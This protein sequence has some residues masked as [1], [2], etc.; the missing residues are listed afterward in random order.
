MYPREVPPGEVRRFNVCLVV[1]VYLDLTDMAKVRDRFIETEAVLEVTEEELKEKEAELEEK[2]AELE[3]KE[4]ALQEKEGELEEKN[5]TIRELEEQLAEKESKLE[6]KE[7]ALEEKEAALG[8]KDRVI[9]ELEEQ[10]RQLSLQR[11]STPKEK[12]PVGKSWRMQTR[13]ETLTPKIVDPGPTPRNP[14]I[15]RFIDDTTQQHVLQC[16]ILDLRIFFGN[17]TLMNDISYLKIFALIASI[18]YR[19]ALRQAKVSKALRYECR[20][21]EE[22]GAGL[23]RRDEPWHLDLCLLRK[24]G[25][26]VGFDFT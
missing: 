22:C 14:S 7:T 4:A 25:S 15:T 10:L 13:L 21:V 20:L 8:E 2:E 3:E 19:E 9:R 17:Y 26:I 23:G 18:D 5:E 24:G 11:R 1:R 6:E 16:K 12:R